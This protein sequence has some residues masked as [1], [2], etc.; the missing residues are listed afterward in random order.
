MATFKTRERKDGSTSI[1]V[2]VIRRTPKVQE[3]KT[4]TTMKAAQ[5]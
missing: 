3:S 5:K 2:Q 4:Y 1:L